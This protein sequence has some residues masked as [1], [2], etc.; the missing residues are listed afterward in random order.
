[1]AVRV[2]AMVNPP[3]LVWAREEAGYSLEA[4]A[5][6]AGQG[7]TVV[8]LQAWENRQAQPTLNQAERLAIIYE[9]PLAIFSLPAPP[10]L[11]PLAT[12]YRRLPGVRPGAEPAA[13]RLSIR[14]LVHRRRLA[15]HLY[16][17]LGDDPPEFQ[18]RAHLR[19]SVEAVGQR[20]RAALGVSLDEQL[21]WPSEFVA[22][23]QWRVAVERLGVLVC[24]MPGQG[25]GE[26]RGTSIVHFP[27]P[28]AGISSKELPLSKPFTLLHEVA[29]LALAAAA[30]ERP[31]LTEDR[32]E[33]DWLE[34]ERFCEGVAG[35][36]LMSPDAMEANGDV[37][38]QRRDRAWDVERMR[39]VAKRFRVTPTA[40]ATRLLRMGV[41]SPVAYARWKTDW[42]TYREA[43]PDR[44]G[45]GIASPAEKA[46]SRNGPLF[47]SLVLS[48]LSG[49]RISSVDA[50]HYLD[51]GFGH[52]ETL[53][54]G[55]I[56]KPAGL[57]AIAEV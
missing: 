31:A 35:A 19:E 45:F 46:V 44:P 26:V 15:L 23:R 17:E 9:R 24:Q 49:E 21:A 52:V 51:L 57:A 56:A 4:A 25:I 33:P 43:H 1:M 32:G 16:A 2:P 28:V 3:L 30:E 42:Q 54:R 5:E 39:R 55:W 8:K 53:R 10:Q 37:V 11:P 7:I 48:A 36:A 20:L 22:F 50:S 29:H 41:M 14:R 27:L 34:V 40:A 18:L 12:E 13:L 47:T 38:R 6:R